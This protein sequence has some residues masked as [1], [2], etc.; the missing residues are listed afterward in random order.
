MGNYPDGIEPGDPRMPWNQTFDDDRW[1]SETCGTC[2]ACERV[3]ATWLNLAGL[4][5]GV[6]YCIEQHDYVGSADAACEE[7]RRS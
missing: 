5:A 3:P 1:E 2:D 7:W 6:G 4:A